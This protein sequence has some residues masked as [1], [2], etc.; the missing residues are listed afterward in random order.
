MGLR[1][2]GSAA[3]HVSWDLQVSG[4]QMVGARVFPVG[5]GRLDKP[6]GKAKVSP[7]GLRESLRHQLE[8]DLALDT[9]G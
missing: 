1:C 5:V 8:L 2:I 3:V 7:V 6:P 9:V 4:R